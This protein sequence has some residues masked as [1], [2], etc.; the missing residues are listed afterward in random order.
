MLPDVVASMDEVSDYTD[1]LVAE[2][3]LAVHGT[4]LYE[5]TSC[6]VLHLSASGVESFL[7]F[8]VDCLVELP[9]ERIH[10]GISVQASSGLLYH[11][12]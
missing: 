1:G 9:S 11:L 12:E 3:D 6:L 2:L 4:Q 10:A 5:E 7:E 8:L